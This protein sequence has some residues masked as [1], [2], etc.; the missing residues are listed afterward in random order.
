M[1]S[2]LLGDLQSFNYDFI[3]SLDFGV[4][5]NVHFD[6]DAQKIVNMKILEH[7][8]HIRSY[9][10]VEYKIMIHKSIIFL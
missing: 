7:L 1:V 4:Q 3:I 9:R 2:L 8:K 6:F 5:F 10:V